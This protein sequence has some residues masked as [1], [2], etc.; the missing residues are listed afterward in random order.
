M[1][2]KECGK[3]LV[4]KAC[5]CTNCGVATDN[6][7]QIVSRPVKTRLTYV[8]LGLFLGALGIHNFYAGYKST[9]IIQL[10]L[11]VLLGWTIVPLLA[12][13]IWVVIDL[14]MVKEDADGNPLL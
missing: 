10:V 2:C 11:T 9:A 3:E 6:M 7:S 4:D 5:I 8:V 1:F 13:L 14:C 12:V